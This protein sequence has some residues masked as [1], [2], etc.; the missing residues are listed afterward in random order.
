PPIIVVVG[1]PNCIYLLNKYHQEFGRHGN[2]I[3]A[4]SRIISKIGLVTLMTN[5][6]TAIGFVVLTFTDI[7]ILK[8]FGIVAGINIFATFIVSIILIPAIFS[9]LPPPNRKQL[10][11]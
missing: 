7:V 2:K 3:L 4:L 10:K 11:H 9:Y 1:V 8:E 5:F 6:T